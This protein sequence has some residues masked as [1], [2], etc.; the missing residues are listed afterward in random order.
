MWLKLDQI[1]NFET[2]KR[3]DFN[4]AVV[5][6]IDGKGTLKGHVGM[7]VI[8]KLLRNTVTPLKF[9]LFVLTTLCW[10]VSCVPGPITPEFSP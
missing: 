2:W 3:D 1:T 6:F 9:P 8:Y 7:P 4:D 5:C 10:P